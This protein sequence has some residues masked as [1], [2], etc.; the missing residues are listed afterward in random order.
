MTKEKLQ[1]AIEIKK[2]IDWCNRVLESDNRNHRSKIL[3]QGSYAE[4]LYD[5]DTEDIPPWLWTIIIKE[6]KIRKE[7]KIKELAEL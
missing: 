2:E 6:I 5:Y 7:K 1:E 4:N 3:G